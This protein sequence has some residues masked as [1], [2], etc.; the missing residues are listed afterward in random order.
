MLSGTPSAISPERGTASALPF[1]SSTTISFDCWRTTVATLF[2]PRL[3]VTL[4]KVSTGWPACLTTSLKV[5]SDSSLAAATSTEMPAASAARA[6]IVSAGLASAPAAGS[7]AAGSATCPL[8]EPAAEPLPAPPPTRT[9]Y[10]VPPP[11]WKYPYT[12]CAR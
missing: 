9:T 6:E 3:V 1:V 8:P 11:F 10:A 12:A 4:S 7:S 5:S 2:G